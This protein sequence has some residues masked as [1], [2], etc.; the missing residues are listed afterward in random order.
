MSNDGY[1]MVFGS[2]EIKY[3]TISSLGAGYIFVDGQTTIPNYFE[4]PFLKDF[5]LVEYVKKHYENKEGV[6]DEEKIET[7]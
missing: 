7:T 3:Q 5:D 4:A 2:S 1:R 6:S